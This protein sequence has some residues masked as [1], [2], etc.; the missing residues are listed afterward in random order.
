MTNIVSL[1]GEPIAAAP[2]P[3]P[4]V[5]ELAKDILRMAETGEL[6]GLAAVGLTEDEGTYSMRAGYQTCSLVGRL[7]HMKFKIMAEWAAE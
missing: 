7:E 6:I 4:N 2:E 5:V 3:N 1:T